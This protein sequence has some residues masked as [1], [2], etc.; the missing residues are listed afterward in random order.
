VGAK[1]GNSAATGRAYVLRKR[2]GIVFNLK[3]CR[4]AKW[5]G[6]LIQK[7]QVICAPLISS[8]NILIFGWAG[9]GG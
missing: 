2:Q 1:F 6:G 8:R 4:I 5:H 9:S 7:T 3:C